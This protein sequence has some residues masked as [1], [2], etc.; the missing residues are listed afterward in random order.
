MYGFLS[1]FALY[2]SKQHNKNGIEMRN[3]GITQCRE[4]HIV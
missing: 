3:R 1:K 4:I 2:N